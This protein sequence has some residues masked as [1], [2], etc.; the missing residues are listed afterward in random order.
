[1]EIEVK[2]LRGIDGRINGMS[3]VSGPESYS[4]DF[5][6][7]LPRALA[8]GD[9]QITIDGEEIVLEGPTFNGSKKQFRAKLVSEELEGLKENVLAEGKERT[10][11]P[12]GM[13]TPGFQFT[14]KD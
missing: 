3:V 4:E 11:K 7:R 9:A 8:S 2:V 13:L 12:A 10:L 1:M 6:S 5:V 14:V